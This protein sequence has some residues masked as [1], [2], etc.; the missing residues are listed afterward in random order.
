MTPQ[1]P[2]HQILGNFDIALHNPFFFFCLT[3]FKN[4]IC[5]DFWEF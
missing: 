4:P 3:N 1:T 5:G 2:P